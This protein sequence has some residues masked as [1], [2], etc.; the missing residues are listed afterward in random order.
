MGLM[1]KTRRTV[2]LL[3][4]LALLAAAAIRDGLQ[5]ARIA[6]LNRAMEN[7]SVVALAEP[8]PAPALF[9][10][11]Y[12]LDRRGDY[13][14]ALDLYRRVIAVGDPAL[15]AAAEFNSGNIYLRQ[16]RELRAGKTKQQALPLLE[17]AKEAYRHVLRNDSGD[18]DAR[19]NLERTLRLAPEPEASEVVESA[20]PQDRERAPGTV[21][22]FN[23]GLP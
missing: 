13:Q 7:G 20:P 4:V 18:W 16:G 8:L 17:L 23:F 6:A 19:Y 3:A 5:L 22:V 14:A 9:A 10:K 11:A 12:H 1:R 2:V 15:Q 21:R